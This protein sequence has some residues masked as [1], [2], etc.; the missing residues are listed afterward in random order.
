MRIVLIALSPLSSDA[1]SAFDIIN[2]GGNIF[3]NHTLL[4]PRLPQ[5]NDEPYL[6]GT[7]WESGKV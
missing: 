7:E 5:P 3:E 6:S 1:F 2:I 4:S